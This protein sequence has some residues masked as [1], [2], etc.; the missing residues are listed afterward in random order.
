MWSVM[1]PV[2]DCAHLL[3][4][5]LPGVVAQLGER[6]DVHVE[7]VDDA[8]T[9]DPSAVVDRL[10]GGI[11]TYRRNPVALGAAPNFNHCLRLSRG[12][13]VHLLHGD[14]MVLPGFYDRMQEA[15]NDP[16]LV[17]V[18][19][20][21]EYIDDADR[22]LTVT[23]PERAGS[24]IWQNALATMALSNRVRPPGIVV[25]RRAYETVGGFREDLPHAA[26]WE[27]WTRL[28]HAG[29]I[30]YVDDVLA[31]YRVHAESDTAGRIRSGAN[32]R[33]RIEAIEAVNT[34]LPAPQRRPIARRAFGYSAVFAGRTALRR[35]AAR[36]FRT[37]AVQAREA[38]RCLGRAAAPR[39]S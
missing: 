35:L 10:G 30:W 28:A 14:D 5:L 13:L 3:E 4:R 27:M 29:P 17:A 24:G 33:E 8:S 15:W 19:C 21:T 2:H 25:A 20:R 37:A 36:D 11:V 9:D 23:R 31:R 7:V 1:I 32:I 34:L 18:V 26:D 6:S 38:L 16:S 22:P 12:H 39:I